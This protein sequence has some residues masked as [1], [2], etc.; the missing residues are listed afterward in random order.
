[1]LPP[2]DYAA[3]KDYQLNRLP[4]QLAAAG[5]HRLLSEAG[6]AVR[7]W[8]RCQ[9]CRSLLRLARVLVATGRW[10]EKHSTPAALAPR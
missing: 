7:P 10:L 1:M 9:V 4:A 2:S 3:F 6:L 8:L 5:Q